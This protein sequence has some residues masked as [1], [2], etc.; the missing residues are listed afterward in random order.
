MAYR[1]LLPKSRPRPENMSSCSAPD[2]HSNPSVL[3]TP[4]V[5][6]LYLLG[7]G[8][9][10]EPSA[11]G[12]LNWDISQ[13][14][15]NILTVMLGL[16]PSSCPVLLIGPGPWP[17]SAATGPSVSLSLVPLTLACPDWPVL[18]RLSGYWA[19]SPSGESHGHSDSPCVHA[20]GPAACPCKCVVSLLPSSPA[21]A[22]DQALLGQRPPPL[23]FFSLCLATCFLV[24]RGTRTAIKVTFLSLPSNSPSVPCPSPLR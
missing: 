5:D 7:P 11:P 21:A 6:G 14:G 15:H 4:Q 13:A 10:S 12:I 20:V 2:C 8:P 17:I 9:N 3:D 24:P 19:V 23:H 1:L 22:A 18:D 16:P